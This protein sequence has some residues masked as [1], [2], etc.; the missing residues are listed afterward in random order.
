MRGWVGSIMNISVIEDRSG[1]LISRR[2]A[3]RRSAGKCLSWWRWPVPGPEENPYLKRTRGLVIH[4]PGVLVLEILELHVALDPVDAEFTQPPGSAAGRLLVVVFG[5]V[6]DSL[7]SLGLSPLVV[8]QG[9]FPVAVGHDL[10]EPLGI[11]L[12]HV[13]GD[14]LAALVQTEFLAE[15]IGPLVEPAEMTQRRGVDSSGH[16]PGLLSA[17][18][19]CRDQL[20]DGSRRTLRPDLG[21]TSPPRV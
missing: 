12:A 16:V 8:D 10:E 6:E 21:V 3:R 20:A 1:I 4:S 5:L 11:G 13:P 2:L 14:D 19:D 18:S 9:E 7:G 15:F 17:R